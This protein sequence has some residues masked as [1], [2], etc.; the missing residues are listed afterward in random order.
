MDTV[1]TGWEIADTPRVA[2]LRRRVRDAMEKDPVAWD[3]PKRI[4]SRFF[5]EPLPVRKARAIALKLAHMP[6]DLWVGQLFVGS[7]T[8]EQPRLHAERGFP[9]YLTHAEKDEAHRRGLG[10]WCFGHIVPDYPTLLSK[11]LRGICADVEAQ[12]PNAHSPEET[13]FLDSVVVATQGVMDYAARLADHCER[14]AAGQHDERRKAELRR[15]A[16]NLRQVPA[17]PAETFHQALQAVWL[18]HVFAIFSFMRDAGL[19]RIALLPYNP[20]SAAKYEWLGEPYDI[21]GDSQSEERL[22]E[23]A[24]MGSAMDLD[25]EIE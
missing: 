17:G 6:A 10:T 13:A 4:D 23:V 15:M 19:R 21:K 20:S 24:S 2:D 25:V 14:E 16:A 7:M 8:L 5:D 22:R 1:T 11:G 12:R 18:L 9:D 3:C